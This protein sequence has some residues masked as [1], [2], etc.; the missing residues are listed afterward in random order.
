MPMNCGDLSPGNTLDVLFEDIEVGGTPLTGATC[1]VS[2]K[3]SAGST[4][5]NG[6]PISGTELAAGSYKAVIPS[7]V[8]IDLDATYS[9]VGTIT[10]G[11]NTATW[12][13]KK[14]AKVRRGGAC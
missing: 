14:T 9:I 4:V 6:G 10:S 11:G 12:T 7:N 8:D 2:V 3:N 5:S 13:E 1:S